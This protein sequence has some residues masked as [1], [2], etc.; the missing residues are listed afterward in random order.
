[1][2]TADA[3]STPSFDHAAWRTGL[4]ALAGYTLILLV[5]TVVF[6]LVPYFVFYS[7]G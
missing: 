3:E 2:D 7:L 6:F 5:M 1:M 4:G